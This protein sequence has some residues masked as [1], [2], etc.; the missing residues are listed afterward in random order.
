M[1][2][3]IKTARRLMAFSVLIHLL[4]AMILA[5]FINFVIGKNAHVAKTV[6]TFSGPIS[7]GFPKPPPLPLSSKQKSTTNKK[8]KFKEKIPEPVLQIPIKMPDEI[9]P[10]LPK[11][12]EENLAN[13]SKENIFD[14]NSDTKNGVSEGILGGLPGG[15]PGGVPGGIPGQDYYSPD[16]SGS[17]QALAEVKLDSRSLKKTKYVHP[18]YPLDALRAGVEGM[19]II[20]AVIGK[21]GKIKSA[22]II[23]SIPL[24]D[25]A[26]LDAIKKWEY[27]SIVVDGEAREI[28]LTVSISFELMN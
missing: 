16:S 24:L 14:K 13:D 3:S 15:V 7:F 22:K 20:Q 18:V 27:K 12:L 2:G 23:Q 8:T 19:V 4:M 26:A 21:N 9:K 25:S 17:P 1:V 6:V 11:K 10:E 28:T 5:I